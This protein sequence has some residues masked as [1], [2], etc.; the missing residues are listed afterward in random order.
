M[1]SK[2]LSYYSIYQM[3]PTHTSQ[4]ILSIQP[5]VFVCKSGTQSQ[6]AAGFERSATGILVLLRD[7]VHPHHWQAVVRITSS[8]VES[9]AY[10]RSNHCATV[11][12]GISSWHC[13]LSSATITNY[14]DGELPVALAAQSMFRSAGHGA[15]L[16]GAKTRS[17]AG[18]GIDRGLSFQKGSSDGAPAGGLD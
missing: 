8:R 5:L 12:D 6:V 10:S 4:R 14:S 9:R 2:K 18:G 7:V 17:P 15:P 3:L 16:R 11:S 13:R 1:L